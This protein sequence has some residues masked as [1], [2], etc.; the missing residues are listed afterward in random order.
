VLIAAAG[1]VL[2]AAAGRVLIA[3]APAEIGRLAEDT[4]LV[5]TV[6][7]EFILF[8]LMLSA[9]Q[10]GLYITLRCSNHLVAPLPRLFYAMPSELTQAVISQLCDH[11]KAGF[12]EQQALNEILPMYMFEYDGVSRALQLRILSKAVVANYPDI[13]RLIKEKTIRTGKDLFILHCA[14]SH[15]AAGK[16]SCLEAE[17]LWEPEKFVA[18]L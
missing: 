7:P 1:R 4:N 8:W 18:Y 14:F 3:A 17:G 10:V 9:A 15:G 2:I 12:W 5:A 11:I 13:E 16:K 6:I